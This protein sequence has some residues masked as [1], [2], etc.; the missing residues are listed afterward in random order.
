MVNTHK[1]DGAGLDPLNGSADNNPH[2]T[3]GDVNQLNNTEVNCEKIMTCIVCPI[4]CE[5]KLTIESGALSA[6]T[7][8]SCKRGREYAQ[9]EIHDPRRTLTS[10]V[11][12]K[13]CIAR[14]L[15]V[16]TSGAIPKDKLRD[17]MVL[18]AKLKTQ[19]PIKSG[20]VVAEN[21]IEDGISL[22]ACKDIAR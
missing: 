1:N 21:F 7:G 8:N 22:V 9:S 12:I 15:P 6:C 20:D 4:G 3:D 17:A 10:T 14:L 13:S 11:Q 5:M 2:N 18:I 19:A 16:K